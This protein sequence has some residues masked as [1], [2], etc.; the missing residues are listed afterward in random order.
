MS[1]IK[2]YVIHAN[3]DIK[4]ALESMRFRDVL[5]EM[6]VRYQGDVAIAFGEDIN[7]FDTGS[8]DT[9]GVAFR[10]VSLGSSDSVAKKTAEKFFN[11]S[12][13]RSVAL[14]TLNNAIGKTGFRISDYEVI[15]APSNMKDKVALELTIA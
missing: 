1:V 8:N 9:I 5:S 15:K 13:Y 3:M 4:D 12:S 7:V 11:S 6:L 14:V 10:A 2:G